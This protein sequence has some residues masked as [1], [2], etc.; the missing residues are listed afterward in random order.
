MKKVLLTFFAVALT[1]PIAALA[2]NAKTLKVV[3]K[4]EINAPAKVVWAKVDD[5]GDLG[6]WHPAVKKT[7]IVEG[8]D[9]VKGAV[10]VLTLQDGGTIKEKLRSYNAK[11]M[12]FEYTI[13]EGVLPVSSYVSS[14]TVKSSKGGVTT[15]VWKG[16]FKRKDTSAKPAAGQDDETAVKTITSVYKAGLDNLKKISEEAIRIECPQG[17]AGPCST[18]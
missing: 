15:V 8:K 12:T 5:F 14:L 7:E 3:Q 9:N 18:K 13:L 4:I 10:R 1:L 17:A 11:G 6:E 16:N 2:G